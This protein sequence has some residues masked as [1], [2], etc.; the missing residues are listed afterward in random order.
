MGSADS[1]RVIFESE[2]GMKWFFLL[3]L[4]PPTP[5]FSQKGCQPEVRNS[6]SY[7]RDPIVE[8]PM[9]EKDIGFA[10]RPTEVR[11]PILLLTS[12]VT[13]WKL[14]EV[15]DSLVLWLLCYKIIHVKPHA[16]VHYW[17]GPFL[18]F[19]SMCDMS[20]KCQALNSNAKWARSYPSLC[21]FNRS[22]AQIVSW[23]PWRNQKECNYNKHATLLRALVGF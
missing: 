5:S 1:W 22:H 2:T 20:C 9:P 21:T 16:T 8:A 14:F 12:C 7:K 6:F 17:P 19:N 18:P 10:V 11:V 23:N 4:S 13:L 3:S 15:S